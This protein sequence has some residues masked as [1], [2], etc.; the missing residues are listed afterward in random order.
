[1]T[2]LTCVPRTFAAL[3][4]LLAAS[5]LGRAAA[6]AQARLQLEC[7]AEGPG[8]ISMDADFQRRPGRRKFSTEFEAAPGGEFQVGDRMVVV[9]DGVRVGS[10]RLVRVRGGDLVGD[11]NFDTTAGPGD[12]AKPF[13]PDFPAVERGT[14]VA[15]RINGAQVLSCRLR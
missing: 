13:P 14:R 15:V 7:E 3:S 2:E 12:D 8:D 5:T 1:M 11:L 4:L 6:S 10:V 9:V